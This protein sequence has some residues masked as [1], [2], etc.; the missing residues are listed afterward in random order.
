[1]WQYE[2]C[3]WLVR[4]VLE[5]DV[6]YERPLLLIAL[7]SPS[8]IILSRYLFIRRYLLEIVNC[9]IYRMSIYY[10]WYN[11]WQAFRLQPQISILEFPRAKLFD[12]LF[13]DFIKMEHELNC[14]LA[15]KIRARKIY[16]VIFVILF[17][18]LYQRL[19]LTRQNWTYS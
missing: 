10:F 16:V 7:S 19:Y 8:W 4:T 15:N 14:K 13:Y 9:K 5:C 11:Q 17:V 2:V 12:L 6:I 3:I 18:C 1:M